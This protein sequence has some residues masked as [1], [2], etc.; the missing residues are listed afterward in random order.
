MVKVS[1]E[2]AGDLHCSVTHGPSQRQFETDAPVDNRGRGESFSPT[3]LVATALGTCMATTM[4]IV[5]DRHGINLKG[6]KIDVVK[7]MSSK[8]PRR[9]ARLT[10]EI[11]VP[12][13]SSIEKRK[14]LEE[15]ALTCP[16]YI[17]LHPEIEKPVAFRW[18]D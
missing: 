14:A 18:L 9:V 3:D 6:M 16:V 4:G 17:S 2:Y 1:I 8:G 7:E 13:P 10:T 15:A 12:L 5:A 11:H